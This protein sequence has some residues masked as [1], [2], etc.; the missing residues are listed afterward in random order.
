MRHAHNLAWTMH[1][2]RLEATSRI[3]HDE[4]TPLPYRVEWREGY[5]DGK[6]WEAVFEG[7]TLAIGTL[8]EAIFACE[9]AEHQSLAAPG[10]KVDHWNDDLMQL[11]VVRAGKNCERA[12]M[13][14]DEATQAVEALSTELKRRQ[15]P[16]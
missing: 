2:G 8:D 16:T 9:C 7:A 11:R 5:A 4:M 10:V 6:D 12:I 13:T 1:E 14:N 15:V 3:W